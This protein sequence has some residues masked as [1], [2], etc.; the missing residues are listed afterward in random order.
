[1]AHDS[2]STFDPSDPC[3]HFETGPDFSMCGW[4][5]IRRDVFRKNP[6]IFLRGGGRD[7]V[8]QDTSTRRSY[9][10]TLHLED[11]TQD[12]RTC[13]CEYL[14]RGSRAANTHVVLGTLFFTSL[15]RGF[16]VYIGLG[17]EC[18]LL[19]KCLNHGFG[20]V[21]YTHLTLPTIYSV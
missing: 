8:D 10:A 13:V 5:G 17:L 4:K 15:A 3:N 12:F 19:Q 16:S 6:E 1:M 7:A 11:N 9:F 18:E 21:S 14:A 2:L 20:A